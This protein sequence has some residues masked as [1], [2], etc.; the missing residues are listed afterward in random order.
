MSKTLSNK[1]SKTVFIVGAGAS[2]EVKMP[3]GY[4]LKKLIAKA[5]DIQPY[6]GN[7]VPSHNGDDCIYHA[8]LLHG[9][10][11]ETDL[12]GSLRDACSRIRDAMPLVISID[13]FFDQH[14]DNQHIALC[15]KLAIVRT[16]L[17]AE[18][19]SSLFFEKYHPNQAINFGEIE[20]TWFNSFFKRLTE[21]CQKSDLAARLDSVVFIVFN[22]DRCFEHFLYNALKTVYRMSDQELTEL[23]RGLEIYH[24]YGSVGTLPWLKQ[25]DA[26]EFGYDPN[27][28]ELL[29]LADRIKTFAEGTDE[30]SDDIV[31]IRWYMS[32]SRKL[33]FL[34]FAFHRLNLDFLLPEGPSRRRQIPRKVF[35]TAV[36]LSDSD[37][38]VIL[39]KLASRLEETGGQFH[40]RNTLTCSKL[41]HEFSQMLSFT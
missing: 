36:G 22:Y 32:T 8:L 29:T 11:K 1:T 15:G 34:G 39:G 38:S 41:F 26:I 6:R 3:L 10:G 24:P 33:V 27:A 7:Y 28:Q 2:E 9:N 20:S 16:I 17:Q 35:A 23:L 19:G 18:R 13:N 40:F 5:L 31:A 37:V 25:D 30:K 12:L 21:N 14:R 4:D